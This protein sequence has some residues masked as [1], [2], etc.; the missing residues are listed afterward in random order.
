MYS[1]ILLAGG[2]GNRMRQALPKQYLQ[3]AGRPVITH[4]MERVENIEK[5]AEIIVVCD[6]KYKSLILRYIG[7]MNLRKPYS[8]APKGKTRQESVYNG[9][10]LA[11]HDQVI[12]HEAARPFVTV[13]D[14]EKLIAADEDNCT[15]AIPLPF[16]VLRSRDGYISGLLDRSELVN[17]QLPQKFNR[18]VLLAAH[19]KANEEEIVFT[20]DASMLLAYDLG[21]VKILPGKEYNIKL[22]EPL[23]FIVGEQIYKMVF[24]NRR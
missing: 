1:L 4:I 13:D 6:A 22:T 8:L 2:D 18:D 20:E 7:D 23:D 10:M 16:T 12:I 14:F 15:Y 5:I 11:A 21:K 9:L 3:L 17:I 19:M 24:D